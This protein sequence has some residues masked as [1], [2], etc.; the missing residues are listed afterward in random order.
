MLNQSREHRSVLDAIADWVKR[1]REAI[2]LRNEMANCTAEQVA[3][4]ARDMGLSSGELLSITAKGP[5]AADELPRLLRA[6]GVDPQKLGSKDPGTMR[7]L[8]RICITCGHKGRCQHDLARGTVAS[9][10]HNYCPN[11]IALDALFHEN[12]RTSS[13]PRK[14]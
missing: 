5:H 4:I 8:Q 3:V 11:A 9:Q 14:I 7:D 13:E 10:Y 2:G 6:L 1:Y 12:R